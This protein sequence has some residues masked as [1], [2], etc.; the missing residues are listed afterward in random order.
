MRGCLGGSSGYRGCRHTG[1]AH[2]RNRHPTNANAARVIDAAGL[3]PCPGFIDVH[4]YSDLPLLADPR[5]EP[6]IG[7]GMTT[8]LLGA[9]G[10]SDAPLTPSPAAG[11]KTRLGVSGMWAV[12]SLD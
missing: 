9:D 5:S 2:C 3:T 11:R 7:H 12:L 4:S 6:K 1:L 10:L 8:D